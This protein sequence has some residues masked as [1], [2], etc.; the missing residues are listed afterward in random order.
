MLTLRNALHHSSHIDRSL[1][2]MSHSNQ[3]EIRTQQINS[4]SNHTYLGR[5][6]ATVLLECHISR[7]DSLSM[8]GFTDTYRSAIMRVTIDSVHLIVQYLINALIII[9]IDSGIHRRTQCSSYLLIGCDRC[10]QYDR[11]C[12][13][14]ENEF[15]SQ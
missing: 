14:S 13:I 10:W 9:V 15:I 2:V 11:S 3:C 8:F 7:D 5:T 1:V 6:I 4:I 12:Q